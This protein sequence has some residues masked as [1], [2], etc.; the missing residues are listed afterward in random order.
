M[1]GRVVNDLGR[2]LVKCRL[3]SNG[4]LT[5]CSTAALVSAGRG[6]EALRSAFRRY[7]VVLPI[8]RY[9]RIACWRR[10][11]HRR[12][13]GEK[14]RETYNEL[15]AR[16]LA[17]R[18]VCRRARPPRRKRHCLNCLRKW[19]APA[20]WRKATHVTARLTAAPGN[21][22]SIGGLKVMTDNGTVRRARPSGTEKTLT[23]SVQ[24]HGGRTSQA[25]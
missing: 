5:V 23:R 3:A 7:A 14:P 15:A 22:A 16:F 13:R 1:I 17:R 20:R 2:K 6:A 21:G 19:S 11:N 25:D 9:H 18:Y 4:L 10:G 8:R 12:Y 24:L